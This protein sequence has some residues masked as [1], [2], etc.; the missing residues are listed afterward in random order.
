MHDFTLLRAA[1]CGS[2]W[3]LYFNALQTIGGALL[4]AWREIYYGLPRLI[5]ETRWLPDL[6]HAL[7]E[8]GFADMRTQYLTAY[9][10]AIVSARR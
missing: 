3:R 1:P 10:S 5:E 9:G 8:S 7:A 4:P 6:Q 2:L